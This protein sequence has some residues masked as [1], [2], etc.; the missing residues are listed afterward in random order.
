MK[1]KILIMLLFTIPLCAFSP[2]A[3]EYL[4][5]YSVNKYN[6]VY[7]EKKEHVQKIINTIA[8]QETRNKKEI[9]GS[10][11][12]IGMFQII[13][14]TWRGWCKMYFKKVLPMTYE[15]QIIIV[16]MVIMDWL[17]CGLTIQQIAAKWNCGTHIGWERKI[18][19][20]VCGVPYNVPQYVASFVKQYNKNKR[21]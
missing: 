19:I 2:N 17:A 8:W 20:N 21:A 1:R 15:N 5:V 14:A 10:S 7:L 13:P 12:E 9:I 3:T 11:G 18:G 4:N 16:E 6:S